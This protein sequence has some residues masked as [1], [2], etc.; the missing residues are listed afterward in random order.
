MHVR[1][2]GDHQS[3]PGY[4]LGTSTIER[5]RLVSRPMTYCR[6]AGAIHRGRCGTWLEGA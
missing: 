5:D 1:R 2:I 3:I 4:T 6:T